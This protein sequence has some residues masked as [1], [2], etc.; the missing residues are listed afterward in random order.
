MVLPAGPSSWA[1]SNAWP[2]PDAAVPSNVE[3]PSSWTA[4]VTFTGSNDPPHQE[5]PS[6]STNTSL[7]AMPAVSTATKARSPVMAM[8]PPDVADAP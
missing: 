5:L 6:R 3:L 7:K 1:L 2:A 4:M 8:P